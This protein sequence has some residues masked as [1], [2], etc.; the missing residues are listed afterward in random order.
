MLFLT[1]RVLKEGSSSVVGRQVSFDL[2]DNNVLQSLFYCERKSKGK[3][4]E[5]GSEVFLDKLRASKAEHILLFIHGFANFPEDLV[6]QRAEKLQAFF[7]AHKKKFVEVVA[8]VWPCVST[9]FSTTTKTVENYFTDQLAADASGYAFSRALERLRVW[10]DQTIQHAVEA[11]DKSTI[12]LKRLHVL[13]H[14]MGNRVYRQTLKVWVEEHLRQPPPLIIKNSFMFAADLVNESLQRG[15][16]G[17]AIVQASNNVVVYFSADDL[18]L[19]ASK[20]ANLINSIASRRLGHTGPENWDL[21]PS[22]VAAINCGDFS[23]VYDPPF[24]H[25][26]FLDDVEGSPGKAFLHMLGVIQSGKV[27]GKR[28]E[29][30]RLVSRIQNR[31]A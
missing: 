24:G 18:A 12:C 22:N 4:I 6:F 9:E 27:A 17:Q 23:Q 21:T 14:S 30:A 25:T 19:R 26:Y 10:Q 1:N 20:G 5:L 31:R 16:D 7:D 29:E 15:N 28:E 11:K 3:Y 8:L 13:A 2:L